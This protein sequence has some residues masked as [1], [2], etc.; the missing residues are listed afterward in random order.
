MPSPRLD[1]LSRLSP[2]LCEALRGLSVFDYDGRLQALTRQILE[3]DEPLEEVVCRHL[4]ELLPDEQV[5][6][7]LRFLWDFERS[8][9][10]SPGFRSHFCHQFYVFLLGCKI[11]DS[12]FTLFSRLYRDCPWVGPFARRQPDGLLAEMQRSWFLISMGHDVAYALEDLGDF[13]QTYGET[14]FGIESPL[15]TVDI[16]PLLAR[17]DTKAHLARIAKGVATFLGM[18]NV[19]DRQVLYHLVAQ[20]LA[21]WTHDRDGL[22]TSHNHSVASALALGSVLK[23]AGWTLSSACVPAV[24]ASICLHDWRIW[25]EF[26]PDTDGLRRFRFEENYRLDIERAPLA[27]LLVLCDSVQDWGR[28]PYVA[29]AANAERCVMTPH[30]MDFEPGAVHIDLTP[31]GLVPTASQLAE[32]ERCWRNISQFLH[33]S[34]GLGAMISVKLVLPGSVER[35][36]LYKP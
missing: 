18:R 12:N 4:V 25:R 34:P 14:L 32:V 8:L 27:F 11:L 3:A 33:V 19:L 2:E 13:A 29:D 17:P 22:S 26:A 35:Q 1:N 15:L 31:A 10:N 28:H 36:L 5:A 23:R 21:G 20:H 24:Q 9:L 16:S 7:T 30:M 6:D